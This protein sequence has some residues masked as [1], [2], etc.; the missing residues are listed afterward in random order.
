MEASELAEIEKGLQLQQDGRL[1]D[2]ELAY[3]DALKLNPTNADSIHLLGT[4]AFQVGKYE[5]AV[6]LIQKALKLSPTSAHFITIAGLHC[7][8]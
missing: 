7:V 6:Q 5:V 1:R 8:P 2:A 4:L 3:R